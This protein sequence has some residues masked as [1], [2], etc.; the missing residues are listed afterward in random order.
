MENCNGPGARM[1]LGKLRDARCAKR[2]AGQADG[3]PSHLVIVSNLVPLKRVASMI[4]ISISKYLRNRLFRY[5]DDHAE[6]V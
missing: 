5:R 2:S 4:M 3:V 6:V 1:R